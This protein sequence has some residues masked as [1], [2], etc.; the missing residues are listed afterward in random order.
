LKCEDNKS[1]DKAFWLALRNTAIED[2]RR[3]SPHKVDSDVAIQ[4]YYSILSDNMS[5]LPDFVCTTLP[6]NKQERFR[7]INRNMFSSNA[8]HPEGLANQRGIH[9]VKNDNTER[10]GA[11]IVFQWKGTSNDIL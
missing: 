9:A 5:L 6:S 11:K 3:C 2:I 10:K 1:S 7:V 8:F 4:V